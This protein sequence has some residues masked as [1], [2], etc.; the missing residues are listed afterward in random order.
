MDLDPEKNDSVVQHLHS[1]TEPRETE[2]FHRQQ[3]SFTLLQRPLRF[4]QPLGSWSWGMKVLMCLL[5]REYWKLI[6]SSFS[7]FPPDQPCTPSEMGAVVEAEQKKNKVP[8]D[9]I[10]PSTCTQCKQRA[11]MCS[12]CKQ[13]PLSKVRTWRHGNSIAQA[14]H[15]NLVSVNIAVENEAC[16]LL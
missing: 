13:S 4:K 7:S 12:L 10:P 14:W 5:F 16:Y 15:L 2:R 11:N 8:R 3:L 1:P 9:R 6:E